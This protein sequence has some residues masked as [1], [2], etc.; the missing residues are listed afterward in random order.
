MPDKEYNLN[1]IRA[2]LTEGFNTGKLRDFSYDE[3]SFREVYEQLAPNTPKNEIVQLLIEHAEQKLLIEK[4]LAW[5]RERNQDKYKEHI[6][7]YFDSRKTAFEVKIHRHSSIIYAEIDCPVGETKVKFQPPGKQIIETTLADL[8]QIVQQAANSTHSEQFASPTPKV[9]TPED[10]GASLYKLVFQPEVIQLYEASLQGSEHLLPIVLN[11]DPTLDDLIK[12]PWEFLYNPGQ[13]C[14]LASSEKTPLI[15][16]HQLKNN[17][18]PYAESLR[19]LLISANPQDSLSLAGRQEYQFIQDKLATLSQNSQRKVKID[20]LFA[21]TLGDL[22]RIVNDPKT[23]PHIIHSMGYEGLNSLLMKDRANDHSS[24]TLQNLAITLRHV[25]DLRLVIFNTCQTTQSDFLGEQLGLAQ[26]LA[27][28]GIPAIVGMQFALSDKAV[29][30]FIETFYG[31][32]AAGDP[33]DLA[34][35]GARLAMQKKLGFG[36]VEWATPVLYLQT[37][38][39]QLFEDF[40][41]KPEDTEAP[42]RHETEVEDTADFE[43]IDTGTRLPDLY[44][45]SEKLASSRL[46]EATLIKWEIYYQEGVRYFDQKDWETA[47]SFL[48]LAN[49]FK[50]DYQETSKYLQTAR[51]KLQEQEQLRQKQS[52][53]EILAHQAQQNL[54]AKRWRE[55]LDLL[56]VVQKEDAT[57]RKDNIE[58]MAQEAKANYEQQFFQ[59][60]LQLQLETLYQRAQ[61]SITEQNWTRAIY[62]LEELEN[63]APEGF[64]NASELLRKAHRQRLLSEEY[65]KG[66]LAFNGNDWATA[67]A[68]FSRVYAIDQDYPGAAQMLEAAQ[69]EQDLDARYRRGLDFLVAERWPEAADALAHIPEDDLRRQEARPARLYAQARLYMDKEEWEAAV[70]FLQKLTT[71]AY[72]DAG[73]QLKLAQQQARWADLFEQ[74]QQALEVSDWEDAIS[75]FGAIVKD[76]PAYKDG[77]AQRLLELA[78]KEANLNQLYISACHQF[79]AENWLGAISLLQQIQPDYKDVKDLLEQAHRNQKWRDWY[80]QAITYTKQSQWAQALKKFKQL[81]IESPNYADAANHLKAVQQQMKLSSMYQAAEDNIEQ[82]NWQQAVNLL[83]QVVAEQPDFIDAAT[84]L[85]VARRQAQLQKRYNEGKDHFKASRW[86]EAISALEEVTAKLKPDEPLDEAYAD[87]SNLLVQARQKKELAEALDRA[88]TAMAQRDWSRAIQTLKSV[89]PASPEAQ[90]LLKLAEEEKR[91]KSLYADVQHELHDQ[92]WHKVVSCLE[93]IHQ[94]RPAGYE[95]SLALQKQAHQEL[96][97]FELYNTAIGHITQ[98]EWSQAIATLTQLPDKNCDYSDVSQLLASAQQQLKLLQDYEEAQVA[99]SNQAWQQAVTL[100]EQVVKE[101]ADFLDAVDLL[102]TAQ[103]QARLSE[104]YNKSKKYLGASNLTNAIR[105]LEELQSQLNAND[106]LDKVYSDTSELL[107][108]A[109]RDKELADTYHSAT[110]FIAEEKWAEAISALQK[111][112]NLEPNHPQAP[113]LLDTAYREYNFSQAYQAGLIAFEAEEWEKALTF[114]DQALTFKTD[115]H[116]AVKMRQEAE[117]QQAINRALQEAYQAET[118]Q[119]WSDAVTAYKEVIKIDRYHPEANIKL[120][121]AESQQKLMKLMTQADQAIQTEEWAEAIKA[122]E[123]VARIDANYGQVG[124]KLVKAKQQRQLAKW[125]EQAQA[126][127]SEGCQPPYPRKKLNSAV[128]LFSQI[129]QKDS[130]YKDVAADLQNAR[131]ELQLLDDY[132]LAERLFNVEE[133]QGAFEKFQSIAKRRVDYRSTPTYLEDAKLNWMAQ[134]Y[135]HRADDLLQQLNQ[136]SEENL[137]KAKAELEKIVIAGSG[138]YGEKAK[139]KM[140]E[141]EDKLEV[142]GRERQTIIKQTCQEMLDSANRQEWDQAEKALSALHDLD[143]NHYDEYKQLLIDKLR[144]AAE[145]AEEAK[146]WEKTEYLWRRL[147][148]FTS[149]K[150]TR[151]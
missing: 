82:R 14:F 120:K 65:D 15:R 150:S 85:S 18:F 140:M 58:R 25:P 63:R 9:H 28:S 40:F 59:A 132:T 44:D 74:G 57:F 73:E 100:L 35:T 103:R 97:C 27:D 68:H 79:Q 1:H 131:E 142:L 62:I 26:A 125:Y 6:P 64:Q 22:E 117:Q 36:S 29:S 10:M 76:E 21:H 133:W 20:Y 102:Q 34:V 118:K 53:L 69:R 75:A 110:E 83:Q 139:A 7:Y 126:D 23:R 31:S 45:K 151:R 114:F 119:E 89:A 33:I 107:A 108:K 148:K 51:N 16:R 81:L 137:S 141:I 24:A 95:D 147:D 37:S 71:A 38:R 104:L 99:L 55:A 144:D 84:K 138:A 11:I 61:E 3:L 39:K 136:P 77:E 92:H 72:L 135:W 121:E 4:L 56:K 98:G 149:Q 128:D 41:K 42:L 17:P 30:T 52:R 127:L 101:Q 116:E 80:N 134:Q 129:E 122:L 112:I 106:P 90:S 46:D 86:A 50:A 49:D 109:Q 88:Q 93:Q 47:I 145:A 78:E 19:V 48:Q 123:A 96:E 105:T 2:L 54:E 91:L 66:N 8:R 32:I 13:S 143:P 67:V 113:S 43:A 124:Q 12:L 146:E 115:H 60:S 130:N 87:A 94:I 111:V 5:A 70:P